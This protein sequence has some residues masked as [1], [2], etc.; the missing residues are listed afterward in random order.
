MGR[1]KRYATAAER[2]AAYRHRVRAD[3][4]VVDRHAW[5]QLE[6]RLARLHAAITAA[7]GQGESVAQQVGC[8]SVDSTLD[9]LTHWFLER[10]K[11][12]P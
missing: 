8:V 2:Q 7:R 3:T 11:P 5:E 9:Q 1:Q 10:A 6:Q 12:T 4:L